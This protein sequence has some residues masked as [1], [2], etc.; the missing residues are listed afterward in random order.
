LIGKFNSQNITDS[1]NVHYIYKKIFMRKILLTAIAFCIIQLSNAIEIDRNEVRLPSKS[2][3]VA[4][5]SKQATLRKSNA[6]QSFISTNGTWFVEFDETSGLPAKA[7]GKPISLPGATLVEK[8]NSFIAEQLGAFGVDK[9]TLTNYKEVKGK[10]YTYINYKQYY[11]GI[12][13]L[14]ARVSLKFSQNNQL[15]QFSANAGALDISTV[16]L[17]SE[18]TAQEIAVD[19]LGINSIA[20]IS[21]GLKIVPISKNGIYEHRLIYSI[22]VK[23]KNAEN[24]PVNYLTYIDAENSNVLMRKNLVVFHNDKTHNDKTNDKAQSDKLPL[25]LQ[26]NTQASI[27]PNGPNDGVLSLSGMPYAK[28]RIDG[29]NYYTDVN[30]DLIIALSG[31]Q[32]AEMP[33]EG[34]FAKIVNLS[35]NQTPEIVTVLNEGVNNIN[36]NAE[37]ILEER[38]A[39][40]STNVIHDHM[41]TVFPDFTNC[42]FP[43]QVNVETNEE[44]CNAFYDGSSLNFFTEIA[45]CY[46]LAIVADVVYHE[47][48]HNIN[49]LYYQN[50]GAY[51][52][53][54]AMNEGYAD[55][56]AFSVYNDPILA[57]GYVPGSSEDYIRRYDEAPKVYPQD[58]IGEVHADGE[59]IAGAWWDTYLNLGSNMDLTMQLF[60]EAFNGLQAEEFDGNEGVAYRNVLLDVLQAD[61]DDADIVNGTPNDIAILE[62]FS[63]HG[64]SLIS[65]ATIIHS[66]L[67][68]S[69][70]D[71]QIDVLAQLTLTFPWS[72]YLDNIALNYKVNTETESFSVQLTNSGGDNYEGQIPAQPFGTLISY[73]LGA[74][75]IFGQVS[76]VL[77]IG[78]TLEDPN[79]PY[80]MLVGFDLLGIDDFDDY[81][82][83]GDWNGGIAADNNTT[84]TWELTTPVGS[85]TDN[86]TEVAPNTQNTEFGNFCFVTENSSSTSSPIGSADVDGGTTT[87]LSP[88][89]DLSTMQNPAITYHRWYIN[90]PPSGANPNADWWQVYITNNGTDW[91]KIE[92]TK[93]SDATWRR[94]AFRVTDYVSLSNTIQLRFNVSDSI[95]TGEYLDGGSLVEGALDDIAVWEKATV[96][97]ITESQ[98]NIIFN[99]FPT[100]AFDCFTINGISESNETFKISITDHTGNV[101]H[102]N[103]IKTNNKKLNK[104]IDI[105]KLAS[106]SYFITVTGDTFKTTKKLV[107]IK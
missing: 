94:F 45:D 10:K 84:G 101:V 100:P 44:T 24:I 73:Y 28:V 106:G 93:T 19:L 87:L 41:K 61:D 6:W 59:I 5:V 67:L 97:S 75:D 7:Y 86:L 35:T 46:S 66:Q 54:G 72:A 50:S 103:T 29:E 68:S 27:Y 9:L 57:D 55:V 30:G 95:R 25:T 39:Y 12:E 70:A 14:G 78:A 47:Y 33:L 90:N 37:A 82:D 79:L 49:D 23:G 36:Y 96:N 76:N 17:V 52:I 21:N 89:Y 31:P 88:V 48:G 107:V 4:D 22:N 16:A 15:V 83:F 77:P 60:G 63:K 42:D 13:V 38:C 2:G 65:N 43:L 20:S 32:D 34:K 98:K 62:A 80:Y 53:N 105:S 99:V 81:E 1:T 85:Y 69:N 92:E 104:T 3:N 18:I 58:I 51:F 8:S 11:Q 64:I 74:Q 26:V 40:K 91:V 56:W 102:H 71:E